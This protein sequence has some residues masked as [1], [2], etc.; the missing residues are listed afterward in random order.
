[1]NYKRNLHKIAKYF[2]LKFKGSFKF[3]RCSNK[4]VSIRNFLGSCPMKPYVYYGSTKNNSED[5]L[6]E[7]IQFLDSSGRQTSKG[8]VI[9]QR[10]IVREIERVNSLKNKKLKKELLKFY[11]KIRKKIG[12][13]NNL[14][15]V[16]DTEHPDETLLHE[17]VH[18]LMHANDIIIKDIPIN[19]GLVTYMTHYGLGDSDAFYEKNPKVR[20]S[21]LY[22]GYAKRIANFFKN[23]KTPEKR[24]ELILSFS[25]AK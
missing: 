14:T 16:C 5:Y 6:E 19:E 12:R 20:E 15:L 18:E 11:S 3:V 10:G 13:A 1:M 8:C 9:T 7:F 4:E 23:T 22:I 25:R 2:G 17:F 24:K 21:N